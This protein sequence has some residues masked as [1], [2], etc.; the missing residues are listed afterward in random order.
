[1]TKDVTQP[2]SLEPSG[3]DRLRSFIQR[4]ERLEADKAEV[5][6]DMKEVYAE[7]KAMGFDTKIMR[8]VVRLR[9]MDSQDRAEQE[10]VLNLYLHAV[11]DA[12]LFKAAGEGVD[13]EGDSAMERFTGLLKRGEVSIHAAG[14]RIAP[15]TAATEDKPD[16]KTRTKPKAAAA[17]P[18]RALPRS[19]PGAKAKETEDYQL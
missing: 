18:G 1:M 6:A 4:V 15:N 17:K 13:P 2:Q 12:P 9:K 10:A 14:K 19:Q 8:Q 7:A 11:G 16:A 3:Q 5:M